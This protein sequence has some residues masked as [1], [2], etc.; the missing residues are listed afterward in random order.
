MDIGEKFRASR[1]V[2]YKSFLHLS[3]LVITI[4]GMFGIA[5]RRMKIYL[6]RCCLKTWLKS[7]NCY[8]VLFIILCT[9]LSKSVLITMVMVIT[10]VM[11]A[12]FS[13]V[14]LIFNC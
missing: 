9:V 11:S 7:F 1:F 6:F 13:A 8:A 2:E 3:S 12:V 5:L 4:H 14:P 10:M